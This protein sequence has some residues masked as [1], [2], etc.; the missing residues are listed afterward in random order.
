MKANL[1]TKKDLLKLLLKLKQPRKWKREL[2][3]YFTP[4]D[5][6]ADMLWKIHLRGEITEKTVADFGA[7]HGI[8]GIA[9]ALLGARKVYLVEIDP[10]L[11]ELARSNVEKLGLQNICEII[12]DD[13]KHFNKPVDLVIQ[14][15]PFG[16]ETR[17]GEDVE[18]L[19]A[20]LRVAPL[21]Y[22]MHHYHPRAL[23]T[24]VSKLRKAYPGAIVSV[25]WIY[26]FH[27]PGI[28]E[29]HRRRV[30]RYK[31]A[32]LRAARS[33]DAQRKASEM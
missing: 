31:V 30:H 12:V 8:L 14:N 3:Q 23:Q 16:I 5:I 27:I 4:P 26:E 18:F 33:F 29:S 21:V 24:I 2:E 15:P 6:A 9:A 19:K 13:A 28:L 11:A 1:G 32:V 10:E 25:V 22:S 17:K 20:A 7:G